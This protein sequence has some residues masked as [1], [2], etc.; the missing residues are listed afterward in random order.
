MRRVE[1]TLV[2]REQPQ[3]FSNASDFDNITTILVLQ[4][5]CILIYFGVPFK[6]N[7]HSKNGSTLCLGSLG[8]LILGDLKRVVSLVYVHGA[9]RTQIQRGKNVH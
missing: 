8:L 4:V 2:V 6:Q 9:T 7:N 1:L 5:H 3:Q